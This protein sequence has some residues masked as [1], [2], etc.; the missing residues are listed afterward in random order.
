ME[1]LNPPLVQKPNNTTFTL[2]GDPKFFYFIDPTQVQGLFGGST[3]TVI[4][5]IETS[6]VVPAIPKESNKNI[7]YR[8]PPKK[9]IGMPHYHLERGLL[10]THSLGIKP[11]WSNEER[12][13]IMTRLEMMKEKEKTELRLPSGSLF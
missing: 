13:K 1:I 10:G 6:T 12:M 4:S 8:S 7:V 2:V 9:N 11:T 5:Q 3:N